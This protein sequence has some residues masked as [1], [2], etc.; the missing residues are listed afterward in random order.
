MK[1]LKRRKRYTVPGTIDLTVAHRISPRR[2]PI[3]PMWWRIITWGPS[4]IIRGL[5]WFMG[6]DELP[7]A[8]HRPYGLD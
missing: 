6:A 4:Q 2:R 5:N 7:R 3:G 1:K 8:R